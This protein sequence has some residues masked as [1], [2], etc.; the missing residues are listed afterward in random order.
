MRL[1]NLN[2]DLWQLLQPEE[3]TADAVVGSVATKNQRS[4]A[5]IPYVT[6][7]KIL[8]RGESALLMFRIQP[9]PEEMRPGMM[10]RIQRMWVAIAER[11]GDHY[12]GILNSHPAG[13]YTNRDFY[14]SPGA[15]IPF[16]PHHIIDIDRPPWGFD[17]ETVLQTDTRRLWCR[18]A[19]A[20]P[21]MGDPILSNLLQLADKTAIRRLTD[22]TCRS[23]FGIGHTT[24]QTW[25][26]MFITTG[27]D[28]LSDSEALME[29][30]QPLRERV[31]QGT[32]Q[33][34]AVCTYRHIQ[35]TSG[36]VANAIMIL[37]ENT[38]GYS[39]Y[40][41]RTYRQTSDGYEFD[42][43]TAQFGTAM[44]FGDN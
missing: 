6:G 17:I 39:V 31:S 1:A 10:G 20:Q 12:I 4:P 14:L 33:A 8:K 28:F 38:C 29:A 30:V 27:I 43:L 9:T 16:L 23:A 22:S 37:L 7:E 15:E 44:V 13:N 2:Y 36:L 26:D 40:W 41:F 32:L 34:S 19:E 35:R 5:A 3:F 24:G 11:C 18:D 21:S 25:T 42:D